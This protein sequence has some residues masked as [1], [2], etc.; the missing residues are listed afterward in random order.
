MRG[1]NLEAL[2][3]EDNR[4]KVKDALLIVDNEYFIR[5][6]LLFAFLSKPVFSGFT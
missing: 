5:S 6:S 1:F 4:E 3:L 2:F